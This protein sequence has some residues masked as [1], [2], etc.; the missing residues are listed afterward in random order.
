[1][2]TIT[3]IKRRAQKAMGVS[4]R[5]CVEVGQ[6]A[7]NRDPLVRETTSNEVHWYSPDV[8]EG[9]LQDLSVLSKGDLKGPGP[10]ILDLYVHTGPMGHHNTELCGNVMAVIASDGELLVLFD[11]TSDYEAAQ[12]W[13]AGV[14]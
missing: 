10:I 4:G 14:R 11:S 13:L 3:E 6:R 12:W 1:M 8:A 5:A 7:D 9:G 2:T